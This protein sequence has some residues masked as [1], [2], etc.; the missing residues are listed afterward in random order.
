[1][2]L[3][4]VHGSGGTEDGE[5]GGTTGLS[6]FVLDFPHNHCGWYFNIEEFQTPART[7][8]LFQLV[9]FPRPARQV[10][11][12]ITI[13]SEKTIDSENETQPFSLERNCPSPGQFLFNVDFGRFSSCLWRVCRHAV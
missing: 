8:R 13:D 11:R 1:M 4:D 3:K 9:L 12:A 7:D 2:G 6:V 5:E 10:C